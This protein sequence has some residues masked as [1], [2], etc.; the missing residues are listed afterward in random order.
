MSVV[1]AFSVVFC[2]FLTHFLSFSDTFSVMLRCDVKGG[3]RDHDEGEFYYENEDSSIES[4]D[5][6]NIE[7][8]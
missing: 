7:R 1:D 6:F 2:H 5:S 4:D 8:E 3:A